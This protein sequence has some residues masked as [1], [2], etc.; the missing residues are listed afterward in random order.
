MSYEKPAIVAQDRAIRAIQK[1]NK[2]SL[3]S[4]NCE[5]STVNAYEAD[6]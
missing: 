6:E 2:P 3:H 1:I 5:S 4:D